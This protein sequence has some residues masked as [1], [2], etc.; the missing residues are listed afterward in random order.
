MS[1]E[2]VALILEAQIKVYE[3]TMEE[4][5]RAGHTWVLGEC[6]KHLRVMQARLEQ[7]RIT[8]AEPTPWA[9]RPP[10]ERGRRYG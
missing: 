10:E 7:A 2:L 8:A 1:P 3:R 9:L 6:A 4:A 5:V